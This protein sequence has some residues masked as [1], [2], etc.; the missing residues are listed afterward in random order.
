MAKQNLDNLNLTDF[1]EFLNNDDVRT[2]YTLG[3]VLGNGTY[4]VVRQ[5]TNK[6]TGVGVAIKIINK[7]NNSL[8]QKML[9]NEKA[10]LQKVRHPN[11]IALEALYETSNYLFFVMEL[12][13]GGEL[14]D[15]LMQKGSFSEKEASKIIRQ[16][17]EALKY[18]HSLGIVHRDLKPQNILCEL[19]SRGSIAQVKVTDFGLS[20]IMMGA[21]LQSCVGSP[22][23]VAPELLM[24]EGYGEKVD[25]WSVGCICYNL[26]SGL[27]PFF[28]E[29]NNAL[30]RAILTEDLQLPDPEW[31]CISPPAKNLVRAMLERNVNRRP[32]AATCLTHEWL[33]P[34][35]NMAPNKSITGIGDKLRSLVSTM[36]YQQQP[37]IT[38]PKRTQEEEVL[39]QLYTVNGHTFKWDDESIISVLIEH[40]ERASVPKDTVLLQEGEKIQTFYIVKNGSVRVEK[41]HDLKPLTLLVYTA[42]CSFG[43][44]GLL[45]LNAI[46]NDSKVTN[47]DLEVLKIQ[48]SQL[49]Q[50]LES[51]HQLAAHFYKRVA[52]DA[53]Q[54]L[55][56]SKTRI[57]SVIN[58][59][60]A[61]AGLPKAKS[62][63]VPGEKEV[64]LGEFGCRWTKKIEKFGTLYVLPS[65]LLATATFFSIKTKV[66]IPFVD[67]LNI[68]H[69]KST[70]FLVVNKESK[71]KGKPASQEKISFTFSEDRF[72]QAKTLIMSLW[73]QRDKH[74]SSGTKAGTSTQDDEEEIP[75]TLTPADWS[76]LQKLA[77]LKVFKRNTPIIQEGDS[78]DKLYYIV[79]GRCRAIQIRPEDDAELTIG[80]IRSKEAFGEVGFVTN[81]KATASVITDAETTA[82]SVIHGAHVQQLIENKP[83]FAGRFYKYLAAVITARLEKRIT[84]TVT[85]TRTISRKNR[86]PIEQ[87]TTL[88][89]ALKQRK[90]PAT[91][92]QLVERGVAVNV[93]DSSNSTPLHVAATDKN[94]LEIVA[95]LI[96]NKAN[97]NSKDAN[98]WTPLHAA[99]NVGNL[100]ICKFLLEQGADTTVET[101]EGNLPLHYFVK[102]HFRATEIPLALEVCDMLQAK[103][104]INHETINGETPLHYCVLGKCFDVIQF[105]IEHGANPRSANKRGHR[106]IDIARMMKQDK[107]LELLQGPTTDS[108]TPSSPVLT[109][110]KD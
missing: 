64:F 95:I 72:E 110:S 19:D 7:R 66:S 61:E 48:I 37:R 81:N 36:E 56:D 77:E 52:L 93:T 105:L 51:N 94:Y 108:P 6:T 73:E 82:L 20:K 1:G 49:S 18:L 57:D 38:T 69:K 88:L 45:T 39:S 34:K 50:L 53:A 106:A 60:Y 44:D 70:L 76:D 15:H 85:A 26:L 75:G 86:E 100:E 41:R 101:V 55:I 103:V 13:T 58:S 28:A 68:S 9:D 78:S 89:E 23:Y 102:N 22:L 29:E 83:G 46:A 67:I 65:L 2:H 47:S 96:Q 99:A 80:Y 84:Q 104:N 91:I 5:A 59:Q 3:K 17:L 31:T 74:V 4:G 90:P 24:A 63:I 40:A 35:D 71:K 43:A 14:F 16:I 109:A 30:F 21:T 8:S 79:E 32:D 33:N 87:V 10:I 42:P 27:Y 12:V 62:F 107:M 25:I 92:K 98:G 11:I 97:V 54:L